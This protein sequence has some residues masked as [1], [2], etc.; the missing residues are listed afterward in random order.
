MPPADQFLAQFEEILDDAVMHDGE[1]AVPVRMGIRFARTA[2]GS[3][4][5]M[6]DTGVSPKGFERE[7]RNEIFELSVGSA[8]IDIAAA[9][10]GNT[11]RIIAP[12]GKSAQTGLDDLYTVA[13]ASITND[14]A[15]EFL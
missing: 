15:H 6:P 7:A 8:K 10:Y 4:S 5:R 13:I 12:V 1:F 9:A 11:R 14:A 3:P 2:M